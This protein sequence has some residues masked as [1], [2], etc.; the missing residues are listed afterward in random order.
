MRQ[1]LKLLVQYTA[2]NVG[3]C[4][5]RRTSFNVSTGQYIIHQEAADLHSQKTVNRGI[6][7]PGDTK[8]NE[9]RMSLNSL[10]EQ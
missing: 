4:Q 2:E 6:N 8:I 7:D 9:C 3:R 10:P 1:I 5:P